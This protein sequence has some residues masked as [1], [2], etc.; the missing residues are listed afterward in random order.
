VVRYWDLAATEKTEL[1]DPDWT[2]GIEL[3]RDKNDGYWLV[4]A[5]RV[6][7]NPGDV[8]R[9]L[10]DTA[11]QDG[12]K[13]KIGF[14]QDPGQAGKSQAQ[15][16]VRAL[17]SFTVT[18]A[19]ESGDKRTRFGPFSSQCRAG[20]VKILRGS[21]NEDLFRVLEGFPELAHDDEVDAS[22]D[23]L[24]MLKPEMK[25]RGLYGFYRQKAEK[26]RPRSNSWVRLRAPHGIGAVQT[27]S[28]RRLN[29]GEDGTVLVS[30][31]DAEY[32]IGNDWDELAEWQGSEETWGERAKLTVLRVWAAGCWAGAE[33]SYPGV[34]ES[35]QGRSAARWQA[36]HEFEVSHSSLTR[37]LIAAATKRYHGTPKPGGP[38][39]HGRFLEHIAPCC[40]PAAPTPTPAHTF[41]QSRCR[42]SPE[43]GGDAHRAVLGCSARREIVLDTF[44]AK[45]QRISPPSA[46]AGGGYRAR[47]QSGLPH[48]VEARA[49][50][51]NPS[52]C[53]S[54]VWITDGG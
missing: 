19:T 49:S 51:P 8:E 4:D 10:L 11:A 18:P 25:G 1:N 7:A 32:L 5:V 28:G 2:V 20:N 36:L 52:R 40:L 46:P 41:A 31:E 23:T 3:G 29:I 13:V 38:R 44:S 9:L 14:G 53:V 47:A 24:E 26:L 43:A 16:L 17:S 12:N 33:I 30:A 45:A 6:R 27:Y 35:G 42:H 50:S 48:A 34:K 37:A 21:W 39:I 15:Y 22:S 54:L